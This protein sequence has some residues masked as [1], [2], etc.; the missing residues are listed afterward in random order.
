MPRPDGPQ[1]ALYHGTAGEIEGD[2]IFPSLDGALGPGAYAT[3]NL[4]AA[5][6]YARIAAHGERQPRLFGTIFEVEPM[7][8]AS[9]VRSDAAASDATYYVDEKGLRPKKAVGFPAAFGIQKTLVDSKNTLSTGLSKK[10][11]D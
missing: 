11:T 9:E 3:D 4:R 2:Q 1:F 7:S 5:A 10:D 6:H 8:P